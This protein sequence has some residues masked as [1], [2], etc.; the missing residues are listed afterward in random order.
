VGP[1][2]G[3]RILS[4]NPNEHRFLLQSSYLTG[5]KYERYEHDAECMLR[6]IRYAGDSQLSGV[7]V[8]RLDFEYDPNA[9]DQPF[10]ISGKMGEVYR[11][12][13]LDDIDF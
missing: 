9:V 2:Y 3:G 10:P 4:Q 13:T 1:I 6:M 8:Y 11:D 7:A 5:Y 12:P